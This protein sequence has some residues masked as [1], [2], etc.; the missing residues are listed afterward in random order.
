MKKILL[1]LILSIILVPS[2][3]FAA[4]D[5]GLKSTE[6]IAIGAGYN[7]ADQFTLSQTI[8]QY[9]K[10][11][12]SLV[13]TIFIALTVYAGYLWLTASG[14][15]EN[16]TKAKDIIKMATIGLII[17]V[18]AFSITTF[19]VAKIGESAQPTTSATGGAP[20]NTDCTPNDNSWAN[21]WSCWVSGFSSQKSQYPAGQQ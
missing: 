9:I 1:G 14:N 18:S 17:S 5:I 15:E 7:K 21:T 8:G 11:A 13:G 19:V 3:A 6:N 4:P 12:L 16:V 2:L 10:V 20:A